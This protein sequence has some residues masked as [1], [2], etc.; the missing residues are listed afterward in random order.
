MNATTAAARVN[1]K[2]TQA[3]VDGQIQKSIPMYL[4]AALCQCFERMSRALRWGDVSL[5]DD[6]VTG[7]ERLF[8]KVGSST[9]YRDY[10]QEQGEHPLQPGAVRLNKFFAKYG[11]SEAKKAYRYLL[12]EIWMHA[13][14]F[15]ATTAVLILGKLC[16]NHYEDSKALIGPICALIFSIIFTT[17]KRALH[18]KNNRAGPEQ[19]MKIDDWKI[20]R[21]INDNRL[22][23]V[24]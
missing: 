21:S 8:L 23:I 12:S 24:D 17:P 6:P 7:N 5:R 16:S 18:L 13:F 11:P 3:E 9:A 10:D 15:F 19:S 14:C 22:I 1:R 2:Q 20:N 4:Q